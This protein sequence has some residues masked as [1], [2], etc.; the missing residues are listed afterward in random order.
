[1]WNLPGPGVEPVSPALAVDSYP[2]C[3]QG[4]PYLNLLMAAYLCHLQEHCTRLAI[5]QLSECPCLSLLAPSALGPIVPE[6][7]NKPGSHHDG[8]RRRVTT[9]LLSEARWIG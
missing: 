8:L 5:S 3:H 7:T 2:V 4:S 6:D 9:Q 1:M